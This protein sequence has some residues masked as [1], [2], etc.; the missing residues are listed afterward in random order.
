MMPTHSGLLPREGFKADTLIRV[1]GKTAL[2]PAFMLPLLVLA[3]L[4]K[5]GEDYS[6]LHPKLFSRVKLLFCLGL[7]RWLSSWY[8]TGVVNNWQDDLYDWRG[9]EIVLVTG[10]SGGIGGHVARFLSEKGVKVVV[11]DIQPL[12][13][14]APSNVRYFKCDITSPR[15]IAAV[16]KDIRTKVGYPTVLINN[17][18]V[19]R[20]KS[21][22]DSSEKDIRF[23]FDVNSL[24]HYWI[25][26]EFLP[27]LVENNHGMVVTVASIAA[28]CTV[29][30]M[31]DYAASKH[32]A[33]AF[34][35]GLAAELATRYRAP[36]VR[37]VVVNQGY[38]RTP[39][40][41]G[42]SNG[43]P[44]LMPV[45]EPETVAEAIVSQVLSG[46][47]GQIIRPAFANSLTVLA[48][49]PHWY[50]YGLRA[51]GHKIMKKWSGRQV[52]SDLDKFYG[53]RDKD[54]ELGDSNVLVPQQS[55]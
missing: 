16:A 42:Y 27:S 17:A 37:T 38:T 46:K 1:L 19:V 39:L 20:G 31:V 34:H 10:G 36:K 11:L 24:A 33:L 13:Y 5:K 41:E 2:N 45:L 7:A 26:K 6:I 29:P 3:R 49:M 14:E 35:E 50:Q 9:R 8:S 4:T 32:A 55:T 23:T 44:F 47:S 12:T 30:N 43:A 53:D 18:G 28:W 54:I 52:V 21:I 48:A 40:F 15:E 25:I 51:D 22:L